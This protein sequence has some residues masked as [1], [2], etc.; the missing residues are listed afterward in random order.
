MTREDLAKMG[1][2]REPVDVVVERAL[3][4]HMAG[5]SGRLLLDRK[6]QQSAAPSALDSQSFVQAFAQTMCLTMTNN[7]R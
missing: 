1:I 6:R 7:A 2:N 4:A 5:M 3:A